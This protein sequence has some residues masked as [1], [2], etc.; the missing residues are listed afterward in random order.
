MTGS[1][2]KYIDY[3]ILIYPFSYYILDSYVNVMY[4][5]NKMTKSV[6]FFMYDLVSMNKVRVSSGGSV[7]PV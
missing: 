6:L 2:L 5:K 1:K 7:A 4:L 3:N